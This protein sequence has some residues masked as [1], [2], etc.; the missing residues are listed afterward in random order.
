[1]NSEFESL[2][3]KIEDLAQ[4]TI[5][6][7]AEN[8]ELRRTAVELKGENADLQKRIDEAHA[9]VAALF[10]LLPIDENVDLKDEEVA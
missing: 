9:R 3:K 8:A 10:E 6:L 4:L 1:M 5:S 2:A 7:R